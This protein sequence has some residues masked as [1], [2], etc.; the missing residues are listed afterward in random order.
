MAPDATEVALEIADP[1]DEVTRVRPSEALDWA[2]AAFSFAAPAAS[3]VDEALRIPARRTAKVECRSTARDAA[4]DMATGGDDGKTRWESMGTPVTV[5]RLELRQE[6][7][8][9]RNV[10]RA[11]LGQSRMDGQHLTL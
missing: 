11:Q 4:R 5:A 9:S 1:A 6:N 10:V 7:F 3:D 8:R 2:W